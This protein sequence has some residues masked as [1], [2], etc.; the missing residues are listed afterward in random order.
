MAEVAPVAIGTRASSKHHPANLGLVAR[1][2]NHR[3]ELRYPMGELAVVPVWTRAALLPLVAQLCLEHPLIVHLQLHGLLIL[4]HFTRHE[5]L[6]LQRRHTL[7]KR[8]RCEKL[9][10]KTELTCFLK[11]GLKT[12]GFE[13]TDPGAS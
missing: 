4:L 5:H 8:R 11:F 6:L 3:T 9:A 13:L 10:S 12:K 2:P 1:M 7:S